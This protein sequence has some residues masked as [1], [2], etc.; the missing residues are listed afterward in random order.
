[1]E[2]SDYLTLQRVIILDA[3]TKSDALDELASVLIETDIG[4]SKDELVSA[5]WEREEMMSTGIGHGLAIPHVRMEGLSDTVMGVGISRNGISDYSGLDDK[6]VSIIVLI[7]A[8]LGQH[9]IYIRLLAKVTEVLKHSE[10]RDGI[11]EAETTEE[12]YS[13]LTGAET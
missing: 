3:T 2:L 12:I 11:V 9:E 5:I 4:V 1:M 7:G 8:P 13:I 6:P 10:L